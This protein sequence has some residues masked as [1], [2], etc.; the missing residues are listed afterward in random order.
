MP[1]DTT[2][3]SVRTEVQPALSP[4]GLRVEAHP[5]GMSI[6]HGDYRP[7]VN[8]NTQLIAKAFGT[9]AQ[10]TS[11]V[12]REQIVKQRKADEALGVQSRL[13]AGDNA[14]RETDT[15]D[16]SAHFI[17]GYDLMSGRLGA[18][19]ATADLYA[20][21]DENPDA[22]VTQGQVQ[23]M[24]ANRIQIDLQGVASPE[25]R[26]SYL[27]GM[28]AV[29]AE[30][31]AKNAKYQ[32]VVAHTKQ[33]DNFS[34]VVNQTF[35]VGVDTKSAQ[36]LATDKAAMREL[37]LMNGLTSAEINKV[38]VSNVGRIAVETGRPE[39]LDAFD[40]A[41]QDTDKP[42]VTVPGLS[43]ST[44]FGP[45][46]AEFKEQATRAK[47]AFEAKNLEA[48]QNAFFKAFDAESNFALKDKMIDENIEGGLISAEKG[49][50]LRKEMGRQKDSSDLSTAIGDLANAGDYV[51]I[52]RMVADGLIKETEKNKI[53]DARASRLLTFFHE[54]LQSNPTE[55][56]QALRLL[57]RDIEGTG[58]KS[59]VLTRELNPSADSFTAFQNS[60]LMA[61]VLKAQGASGKAV[62]AEHQTQDQRNRMQI[63]E[64]QTNNGRTPEEAYAMARSYGTPEA[65]EQGHKMLGSNRSRD[66]Q[67]LIDDELGSYDPGVFSWEYDM[68]NTAQAKDEI[69][70]N[71]RVAVVN[72]GGLITPEDAYKAEIERF[73]ST[74]VAYK[75]DGADTG[76]WVPVPPGTDQDELQASLDWYGEKIASELGYPEDTSFYPEFQPGVGYVMRNATTHG[77]VTRTGT[78]SNGNPLTVPV[79][80]GNIGDLVSAHYDSQFMSAE[81]AQAAQAEQ[82]AGYSGRTRG[83]QVTPEAVAAARNERIETQRR[84]EEARQKVNEVALRNAKRTEDAIAAKWNMKPIE[85]RKARSGNRGR[86]PKAAPAAAPQAETPV[87][88]QAAPAAQQEAPA[89]WAEGTSKWLAD[90]E[91][92]QRAG[93]DENAGKWTPHGSPE[94]GTATLA[95]GHKL[96]DAEVASGE[97]EI[98]GKKVKYEDGITEGQAQQLFQ[99]DTAIA[100][101][102]VESLVKVPLNADQKEALISLVYNV[103][104]SSFK[105]S[106]ALKAL[107][108]GDMETFREEAFGARGWIN[109]EG[110]PGGLK[111]RRAKEERKFFGK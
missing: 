111:S 36:D 34:A 77:I 42:D 24:V 35:S 30:L 90:M 60:V 82:Q 68:T 32:G 27:E 16:K 17:K 19:Q 5:T 76:V 106:K 69:M 75:A 79:A 54:N 56:Q 61:N 73:K 49:R 28:M 4:S 72:S 25:M 58:R 33:L 52:D 44:T 96:T 70:T 29:E 1:K 93:W 110:H 78:D 47:K 39:L 86:G 51:G 14:N 84:R 59:D 55:A 66:L 81:E 107:N 53:L 102:A 38:L 31:T 71:A 109:Y 41:T 57:T 18:A 67:K 37:G 48:R 64:A 95:Y 80:F 89:V 9:L 8:A 21:Y 101:S 85:G 3:A 98:G 20:I 91:N 6:P 45:A 10:V 104:V 103:G 74:H 105:K 108:K 23:T 65:I 92:D 12:A 50:E 97:I 88:P 13:E 15:M 94:G 40:I 46:I 63:Y 22:F 26:A 87:E 43:T 100:R 11:E 83:P 2:R 7:Q 62:V 99:Q